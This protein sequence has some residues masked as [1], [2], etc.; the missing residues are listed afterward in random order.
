MFH[1][2]QT[3]IAATD[4][5]VARRWIREICFYITTP[6]LDIEP[7]LCTPTSTLST[8]KA[9]YEN[10][11]WLL[12]SSTVKSGAEWTGTP[13]YSLWSAMLFPATPLDKKTKNS[14]L[15]WVSGF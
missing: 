10:R 12:P 7:L 13:R 2:L 15:G 11:T 9:E 5:R 14:I 6:F 1:I 8:P 4:N 3:G